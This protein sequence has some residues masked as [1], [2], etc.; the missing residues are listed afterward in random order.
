MNDLYD[1]DYYLRGKETGKSLYTDYHWLPE[2]TI[3]M[4]RVIAYHLNLK[5][6]HSIMDFGCARGYLVRAFM[7]CGL[8]NVSGVD[9]SEWAI[10]NADLNVRLRLY[11]ADEVRA[12]YDWIVAK[13]VLEHVKGVGQTINNLMEHA[14][15]GVFAIVPLG[16]TDLETYVISEY[17]NDVTH[18]HRLNLPAWVALFARPGWSVEARYR[19]PGIKDNWVKPG[20]E[21]GNGFL[22][23]RRL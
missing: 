20:W 13:D 5:A 18:I 17:E 12:D 22:T 4:A 9:T 16:I 10:E 3:P 1:G 8:P 7:E 21:T 11:Q 19:I 23:C 15:I 14:R 2:L 6:K